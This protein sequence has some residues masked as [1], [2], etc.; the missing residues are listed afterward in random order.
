MQPSIIPGAFVSIPSLGSQGEKKKV[1][2][3]AIIWDF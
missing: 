1:Y 3:S 2:Y